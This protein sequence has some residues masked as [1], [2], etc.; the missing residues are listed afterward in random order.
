MADLASVGQ[1]DS[2]SASTLRLAPRATEIAA[3]I[4]PLVPAYSA[5]DEVLVR[6]LATALVRFERAHAA[7]ERVDDVA[8]GNELAAY[9]GELG[10][11]V[12]RVRDDCRAWA[13]TA[14]KCANDL[15]L[16]ARSRAK[17]GLHVVQAADLLSRHLEE[18]YPGRGVSRD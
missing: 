15:S 10:E 3:E 16:S 12:R 7:L 6:L 14:R 11:A 9:T 17:L 18:R 1:G 4:R 5:G 13:E 2:G 8:I